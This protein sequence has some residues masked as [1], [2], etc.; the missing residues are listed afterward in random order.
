MRLEMRVAYRARIMASRR[1]EL[2]EISL[3]LLILSET[4]D[5]YD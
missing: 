5:S 3:G 2:D 4:I 1:Q